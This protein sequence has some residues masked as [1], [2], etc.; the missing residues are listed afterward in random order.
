MK[1][2]GKIPQKIGAKW[3]FYPPFRNLN[4]I[5]RT[6]CVPAV[7]FCAA[8]VRSRGTWRRKQRGAECI[9]CDLSFERYSRVEG[10]W[11]TLEPSGCP[12]RAVIVV[13]VWASLFSG[14]TRLYYILGKKIMRIWVCIRVTGSGNLVGRKLALSWM[15]Q[16]GLGMERF[17][18]GEIVG[19]FKIWLLSAESWA[20]IEFAQNLLGWKSLGDMVYF[21]FKE[22]KLLNYTI[23]IFIFSKIPYHFKILQ[24]S[25]I[26]FLSLLF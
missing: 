5:A 8:L 18:S 9:P 11:R 6:K 21:A 14:I 2:A 4:P 3:G 23:F 20:G 10:G 17:E 12:L 7:A 25:L 24:K 1:E 16:I 19:P 26:F 22:R 13:K 15:I